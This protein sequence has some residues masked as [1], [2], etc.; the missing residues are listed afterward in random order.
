MSKLI[1]LIVVG[2]L[3]FVLACSNELDLIVPAESTPIVYGVLCPQDSIHKVKILKSFICDS[4]PEDCAKI[5]DSLYYT[6]ATV[7]LELRSEDGYVIERTQLHKENLGSKDEGFF[8]SS[9][10]WFYTNQEMQLISSSEGRLVY[11]YLTIFLPENNSSVFA[12]AL[13][14]P[15]PKLSVNLRSDAT[16]N[17]YQ[18]KPPEAI[19]SRSKVYAQE[20]SVI[21]NIEEEIHGRWEPQKVSYIRKYGLQG[22]RGGKTDTLFFD[23]GWFFPMI[24]GKIKD[25]PEVTGR[26]FLNIQIIKRFIDPAYYEYYSSLH[27]GTD[28]FENMLTN[29]VNGLG[30]FAAY[31]KSELSGITLDQRSLDSLALG[32]ITRQLLF[33]RW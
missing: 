21:I 27:Y 2:L 10:N 15:T 28:L 33:E 17:L 24:S 6:D 14:P 3:L 16:L 7:F 4:R 30:L 20:F 32:S 23:A 13:I 11:Y 1:R 29:I 19:I 26:R 18:A 22:L 8:A 5:P 9:P 12:K 25:N 31:N